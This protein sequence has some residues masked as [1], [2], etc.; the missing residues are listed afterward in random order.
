[1]EIQRF[2]IGD[3]R[4]FGAVAGIKFRHVIS[5]VRII[6]AGTVESPLVASSSPQLLLKSSCF[7]GLRHLCR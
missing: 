5:L 2:L 1:V 3:R 7:A 6:W 4:A